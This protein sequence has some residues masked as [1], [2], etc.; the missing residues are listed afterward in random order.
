[1]QDMICFY[2]TLAAS[3]VDPP[4]TKTTFILYVGILSWVN[5]KCSFSLISAFDRNFF[6]SFVMT[7]AC[8]FPIHSYYL[9]TSHA[10]GEKVSFARLPCRWGGQGAAEMETYVA[11]WTFLYWTGRWLPPGRSF[12]FH[13]L[14]VD[15]RVLNM[16]LS[17]RSWDCEARPSSKQFDKGHQEMEKDT[18]WS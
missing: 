17:S 4:P 18:L 7:A 9:I 3:T 10:P 5:T 1:M 8:L 11:G 16:G 13:P 15:C 2:S 14:S 12:S 6:Q